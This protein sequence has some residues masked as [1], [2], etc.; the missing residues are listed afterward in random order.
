MGVKASKSSITRKLSRGLS[1]SR[2]TPPKIFVGTEGQSDTNAN[3]S[4]IIEV[5]KGEEEKV[6]D[7][8]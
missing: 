4:Q 6:V 5:N 3:Y 7:R 8:Q 2:Q 1:L